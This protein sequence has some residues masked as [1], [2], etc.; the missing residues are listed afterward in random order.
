MYMLA[1]AECSNSGG[2]NAMDSLKSQQE[3]LRYSVIVV[4]TCMQ[5]REMVYL[6]CQ[7]RLRLPRVLCRAAVAAAPAT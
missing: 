3:R 4:I 2:K 7:E 1:L 6:A 5:G